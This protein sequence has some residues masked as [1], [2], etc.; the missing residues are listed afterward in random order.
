MNDEDPLSLEQR[1]L[2]LSVESLDSL[3]RFD[4]ALITL[5]R[6]KLSISKSLRIHLHHNAG[7]VY[8]G[9][10]NVTIRKVC[11]E[12][13]G[14][15]TVAPH[16]EDL[17]RILIKIISEA[18][19][20]IERQCLSRTFLSIID[21]AFQE[22]SPTQVACV[23]FH[24]MLCLRVFL[25]SENTPRSGEMIGVFH[26]LIMHVKQK[27]PLILKKRKRES[28]SGIE[29]DW[30]GKITF[31]DDVNQN[32]HITQGLFDMLSDWAQRW[33]T[34]GVLIQCFFNHI[35]NQITIFL[36][37]KGKDT[38][39]AP[40]LL[41]SKMMLCSDSVR[42]AHKKIKIEYELLLSQLILIGDNLGSS[43][44]K[45]MFYLM[46]ILDYELRSTKSC[47]F[48]LIST[49]TSLTAHSKVSSTS[50]LCC[51]NL[52]L[53]GLLQFELNDDCRS[54]LLNSVVYMT[55]VRYED[56]QAQ[57]LSNPYLLVKLSQMISIPDFEHQLNPVLLAYSSFI[58]T[59]LVGN[60]RVSSSIVL[61]NLREIRS[62][63]YSEG[64]ME[65]ELNSIVNV[66]PTVM[67]KILG[68][69]QPSPKIFEKMPG[70]TYVRSVDDVIDKYEKFSNFLD[71]IDN[72]NLV[73]DPPKISQ[74]IIQLNSDV[75]S[76]IIE[77]L[78]I[79][80]AC[81]L[82]CVCKDLRD[83]VYRPIVWKR[84]Y[85]VRFPLS[86]ECSKQLFETKET[87]KLPKCGKCF[88]QS[89]DGAKCKFYSGRYCGDASKQHNWRLLLKQRIK[90]ERS[91]RGVFSKNGFFHRVCNK[92]GCNKIMRTKKEFELHMPNCLEATF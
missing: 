58:F 50:L 13:L 2:L 78:N 11:L 81:R 55:I 85:L 28:C 6:S 8:R 89:D 75:W 87:H 73:D 47:S 56:L 21:Y 3:E 17:H 10:L 53:D 32:L 83:S 67:K 60:I 23:I 4:D 31:I 12:K 68:S 65:L 69:S 33:T 92:V 71:C 25:E 46:D 14:N 84:L 35:L 29:N 88:H 22:L 38:Y 7:S 44:E 49:I 90:T 37:T 70:I 45:T 19:E 20:I 57:C 76:Q 34:G 79:K 30:L 63:D 80:S 51:L 43:L 24:I 52:V 64:F 16:E 62:C 59:I 1:E 26:D 27:R 41:S 61:D 54:V 66:T 40:F 18:T 91:V 15:S 72:S 5:S 74:C 42:I 86:Y 36:R 39:Y 82:S 48:L 9:L 77:F